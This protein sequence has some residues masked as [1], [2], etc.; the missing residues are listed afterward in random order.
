MIKECIGKD[1]TRFSVPGKLFSTF[2]KIKNNKNN[3]NK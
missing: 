3:K 1:L 2:K